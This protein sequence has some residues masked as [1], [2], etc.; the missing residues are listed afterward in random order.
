MTD[1]SVYCCGRNNYGQLGDGTNYNKPNLTQMLG[2]NGV[3]FIADIIGINDGELVE[4]PEN[5]VPCFKED[6][7]IL[8]INGYVPIQDL[9]K[10]D[11][12]KTINNGFL[13]IDMIGYSEI[14]NPICEERIPDKLYLCCQ[15]EYPE[16][17]EDLIITGRHSILVDNFEEEQLE[18]TIQICGDVYVTNNK[19]RLP[20]CVDSRAK[21]YEKEGNFKIYHMI[22]TIWDYVKY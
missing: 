11:L 1:G 8:T 20:A 10:G 2:V 15:D 9:R 13:P 17:F 5:A 6:S 22:H 7:K 12:V 4:Y 3:G 19:Y 21:S 14:Y 18:N 16:I